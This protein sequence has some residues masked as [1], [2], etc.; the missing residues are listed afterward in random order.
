M[1]Y[2]VTSRRVAGCA[3]RRGEA[4]RHRS[5]RQPRTGAAHQPEGL[6]RERRTHRPSP[7]DADA[8]GG[9]P[10]PRD[11]HR[12]RAARLPRQGRRALRR[13]RTRDGESELPTEL[14]VTAPYDVQSKQVPRFE[15]EWSGASWRGVRRRLTATRQERHID[16]TK[17][18]LKWWAAEGTLSR[19]C[20]PRAATPAERPADHL[21]QLD[22]P[23]GT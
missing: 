19:G 4:P 2:G 6:P 3:V 16:Y 23:A 10:A 9:R 15:R 7:P 14:M 18:R 21:H 8:A 17:Q 12:L 22:P 13:V 11:V 1:Q 5:E 20:R